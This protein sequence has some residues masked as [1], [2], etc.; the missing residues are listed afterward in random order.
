MF[1]IVACQADKRV[2]CEP[3]KKK[4]IK[5]PCKTTAT[6]KARAVCSFTPALWNLGATCIV[7]HVHKDKYPQCPDGALH[8]PAIQA[9]KSACR[10]PK[11]SDNQ[12]CSRLGMVY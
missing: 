1:N 10:A 12:L 9:I 4:A 5:A 7:N 8:K 2:T 11:K 3:S 6:F